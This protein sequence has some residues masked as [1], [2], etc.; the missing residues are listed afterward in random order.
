MEEGGEAIAA[1]TKPTATAASKDD[2]SKM[3]DPEESRKRP[4]NLQN[5]NLLSTQVLSLV[6]YAEIPER[7]SL[8]HDIAASIH[9]SP[10]LTLTLLNIIAPVIHEKVESTCRK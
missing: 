4:R 8:L 2:P 5:T 10:S 7:V 3:D 6:P 1:A 9:C